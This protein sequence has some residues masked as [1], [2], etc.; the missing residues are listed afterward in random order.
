MERSKNTIDNYYCIFFYMYIISEMFILIYF[1]FIKNIIWRNFVFWCPTFPQRK[2]QWE[3]RKPTEQVGTTTQG[4]LLE[5]K[6]GV[7]RAGQMVARAGR[8]T[9]SLKDQ[10]RGRWGELAWRTPPPCRGTRHKFYPSGSFRSW[11]FSWVVFVCTFEGHVCG[12]SVLLVDRLQCIEA[13]QRSVL[14]FRIT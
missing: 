6:G 3:G 13:W 8:V 10:R 2:Y 5:N 11:G 14:L 7:W 12:F 4:K 1:N 9:A